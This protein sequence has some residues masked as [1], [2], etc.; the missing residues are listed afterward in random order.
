M[1][2]SH[3]L[4]AYARVVNYYSSTAKDSSRRTLSLSWCPA[5]NGLV[6]ISI[7]IALNGQRMSSRDQL[8]R[9]PIPQGSAREVYLFLLD[10]LWA[11]WAHYSMVDELWLGKLMSEEAQALYELELLADPV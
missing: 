7:N 9:D 8:V 1:E 5:E 3:L 11:K 10:K 2:I 6:V 4:G